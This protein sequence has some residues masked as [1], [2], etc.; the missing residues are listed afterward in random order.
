MPI[1]VRGSDRLSKYIFPRVN[2]RL[3]GVWESLK[4]R[5]DSEHVARK[6]RKADE[7]L[8]SILTV[9]F[10]IGLGYL[11]KM[12]SIFYKITPAIMDLIL[13]QFHAFLG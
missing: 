7:I 9:V 8:F 3:G 13:I 6:K 5:I 10:M 4:G 11:V 2:T 12:F 1:G